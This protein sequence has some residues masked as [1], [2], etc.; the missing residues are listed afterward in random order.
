MLDHATVF[1]AE[2]EA[3]YQACK[4]MDTEYN[5][6]KPRYIKIL[7][8]SQSALQALNNIDFKSSIAL[9]TAESMENMYTSLGESTHRY[10]RKQSGRRSS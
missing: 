7:T 8:D 10:G 4:Y 3:I 5:N 6:F 2:M 9:K 1:Q